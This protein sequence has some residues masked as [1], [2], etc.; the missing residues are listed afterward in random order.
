MSFWYFGGQKGID[1]TPYTP[2]KYCRDLS[3]WKGSL[4]GFYL[5]RSFQYFFFLMQKE[6]FTDWNIYIWVRDS[7]FWQDKQIF[8][9]CNMYRYILICF[10]KRQNYPVL[11]KN[12]EITYIFVPWV[13]GISQKLLK[14]WFMAKLFHLIT[15]IWKFEPSSWIRHILNK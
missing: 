5:N 6:T 14:F 13:L 11:K 15:F 4:N 3:L 12:L 7:S 9:V 2:L 8:L 10:R 1:L